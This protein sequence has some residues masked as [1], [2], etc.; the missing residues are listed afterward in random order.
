MCVDS[1]SSQG[2]SKTA[3]PVGI[4]VGSFQYGALQPSCCRPA[5]QARRLGKA[6]LCGGRA[7]EQ[8]A[9]YRDFKEQA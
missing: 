9:I 6:I 2:G 5:T 7:K 1:S 3:K 8:N 4:I